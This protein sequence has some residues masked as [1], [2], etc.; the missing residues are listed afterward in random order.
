MK[1]TIIDQ[2]TNTIHQVEEPAPASLEE[3]SFSWFDPNEILAATQRYLFAED[4]A[5]TSAS[6]IRFKDGR[7][8][9]V[10][11]KTGDLVGV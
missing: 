4:D 10:D 3:S 11:C 7:E 5:G 1:I 9:E 8:I 2:R 6:R